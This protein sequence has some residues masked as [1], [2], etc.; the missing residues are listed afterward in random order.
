ME[1]LTLIQWITYFSLA[2][3]IVMLIYR[4]RRI[5]KLPIHLRWELYPV[6]HE[7]GRSHYGGSYMEEFE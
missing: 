1:S 5:A 4:A 6:P 7:K 3:G 2:F